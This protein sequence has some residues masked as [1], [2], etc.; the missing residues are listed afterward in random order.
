MADSAVLAKLKEAAAKTP[1]PYPPN[2]QSRYQYVDA[3][4]VNILA[5]RN[6]YPL[7][8]AEYIRSP[9][10]PDHQDLRAFNKW[11][12]SDDAPVEFRGHFRRYLNMRYS[13]TRIPRGVVVAAV[14]NDQ[15]YVSYSL[16]NFDSGERWNRHIAL[17]KA[18]RRIVELEL[19]PCPVIDVRL[20][21][22]GAD[23]PGKIGE[24]N[25]V[26]V[27]LEEGLL[28]WIEQYP[29]S[30]L[31]NVIGFTK[32]LFAKYSDS[33]IALSDLLPVAV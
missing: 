6:T 25:P 18:M 2:P 8:W 22:E 32:R 9:S 21:R 27:P 31:P 26:P 7:N 20:I 4:K 17:W 11:A 33:D 10:P 5:F 23:D 30:A 13:G 15:F 24:F 28:P 1:P 14:V 29:Q 19:S 16:C 3:C 12:K